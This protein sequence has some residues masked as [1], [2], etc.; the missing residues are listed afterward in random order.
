[1][2]TRTARSLAISSLVVCLSGPGY[3][4]ANEIPPQAAI[5]EASPTKTGLSPSAESA[6]DAKTYEA[7]ERAGKTLGT[8][9]GGHGA[10]VYIGGSAL[11]IALLIVLLVVLL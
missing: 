7:R 11:T 4:V 3:A 9:R 1:M 2:K 6:Q 5:I 8:F 10:G